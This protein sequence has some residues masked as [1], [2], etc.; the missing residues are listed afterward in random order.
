MEKVICSIINHTFHQYQNSILSLDGYDRALQ[1]IITNNI[2][3]IKFN[4]DENF[5]DF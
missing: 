5:F 4:K 2:H 1:W 3:Q